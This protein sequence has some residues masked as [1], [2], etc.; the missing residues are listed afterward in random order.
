MTDAVER[1]GKCLCGTV[2]VTVQTE[3]RAFGA[4]HCSMCRTWTGGPMFALEC[5]DNLRIEGS[6]AVSVYGSSEWAE[7]GFCSHC[8][9]HLFYRLRGQPFYAV[10]VGLLEP[11][12]DL[13]FE[14]QIFIDEK[15]AHYAFANETE[16]LTG[17]EVFER[18][19]P[20]TG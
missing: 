14:H 17:Q 19:E 8:G 5:G 12:A 16:N 7:R 10:P 2:R 20:P 4:C 3:A 1:T 13:V 15:P 11:Q 18:F 6:D 9:T